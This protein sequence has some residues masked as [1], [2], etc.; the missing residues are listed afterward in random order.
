MRRHRSC[1]AMCSRSQTA[2][3]RV[4]NLIDLDELGNTPR[5]VDML[6][7]VE[8]RLAPAGCS[9]ERVRATRR[10]TDPNGA[11]GAQST[12]RCQVEN[13]MLVEAMNKPLFLPFTRSSKTVFAQKIPF[14]H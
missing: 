7:M 12:L 6:C 11:I 2:I 8:P 9:A 3:W 4:V 5:V 14:D 13:V 1:E 10:P